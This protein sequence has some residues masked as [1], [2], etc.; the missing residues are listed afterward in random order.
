MAGGLK[1]PARLFPALPDREILHV[2]SQGAY[3]RRSNERLV[4]S[5]RDQELASVPARSVGAVVIHG[6]AQLTTQAIHLCVEHDVAVH[7]L[8][9]GGTFLAGLA[10]GAGGV[11]RRL[12]QYAALTEPGFVFRLARRLAAAR[13]DSQ[14]RYLLRATRG[15]GLARSSSAAAIAELRARRGAV[16]AA[17]GVAELRG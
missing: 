6:N 14:L 10:V 9:S 13:I 1:V 17:E 3:V 16:N 5:L 7:W 4:V 12:R 11:Q 15:N 2:T 8:T